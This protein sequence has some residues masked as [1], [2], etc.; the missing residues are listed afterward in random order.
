VTGS[1]DRNATADNKIVED[2]EGF[3]STSSPLEAN[4]PYQV[5]LI[6]TTGGTN[7]S[8]SFTFTTGDIK[9]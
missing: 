7:F 1:T 5:T 9:F 4:T 6:G 8:R 3:I 2:N